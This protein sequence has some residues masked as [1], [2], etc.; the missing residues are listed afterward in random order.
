MTS[1]APR[2]V[3]A[4][5]VTDKLLHG[6]AVWGPFIG[7]AF[8]GDAAAATSGAGGIDGDSARRSGD[9]RRGHRGPCGEGRPACL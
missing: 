1:L 7:G 2:T 5:D 6:R 8:I 3:A 9:C 4:P